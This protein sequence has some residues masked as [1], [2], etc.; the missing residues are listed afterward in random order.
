MVAVD[1]VTHIS[2]GLAD[3]N[4]DDIELMAE[5]IEKEDDFLLL[6][7]RNRDGIRD[8]LNDI[9]MRL[10][11]DDD[12][13]DMTEDDIAEALAVFDEQVLGFLA[14]VM[15]AMETQEV[16]DKGTVTTTTDLM[17]RM[18]AVFAEAASILNEI[19][20]LMQT[21][22]LS[23]LQGALSM[24][25]QARDRSYT[26]AAEMEQA[27]RIQAKAEI[28]GGAV[29]MA[30]GFAGAAA[31]VK[32]PGLG[33]ALNAIGG[34]ASQIIVGLGKLDA[35]QHQRASSE[36][37]ADASLLQSQAQFLNSMAQRAD[38]TASNAQ[39]LLSSL[40]AA[41]KQMCDAINQTTIAITSN[42]R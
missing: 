6:D 31:S 34:G 37:T 19:R 3:Y 15:D 13:N 1:G 41:L 39:Q 7:Q 33:Q 16:N 22:S 9:H 42:M 29:S 27:T 11:D 40:L 8:F 36:A 21:T 10:T 5:R 30:A 17:Y 24:A 12:A 38:G 4:E 28:V 32:V 26:A 35:A 14:E 23:D 25:E 2:Q 18:A 20:R